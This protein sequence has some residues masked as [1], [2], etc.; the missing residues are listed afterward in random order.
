ML[1]NH[2]SI[3]ARLLTVASTLV[4]YVL[5]RVIQSQKLEQSKAHSGGFVPELL[6][7]PTDSQPPELPWGFLA[8]HVFLL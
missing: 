5:T 8:L 3:L 4:P 6:Q 7:T 1:P 2:F